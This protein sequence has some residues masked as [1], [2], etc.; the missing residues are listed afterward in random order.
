MDTGVLHGVM[1]GLAVLIS[2]VAGLALA[3]GTRWWLAD[4]TQ[5]HSLESSQA[6][7]RPM[8]IA[9]GVVIAA[10]AAPLFPTAAVLPNMTGWTAY[11]PASGTTFTPSDPN[12]FDPLLLAVVLGLCSAATPF[13]VVVDLLVRRLPDRIVLPLIALVALSCLLGAAFG[14]PHIWIVGLFAGIGATVFFGL[15]HLIGRLLRTST[16]GLG[17]VKLSFIVFTV[18]GLYS[19]WSPALVLVIMML[20]AGLVALAAIVSK[21]RLRGTSIAFGPSMLSGMWLGSVLSPFLL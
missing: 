6:Y 16:M 10:A 3:H 5:L 19:P 4:E 1:V 8:L 7:R 9:V 20:I 11:A 17:D 12:V 14:Q 13:L 18:A 15:L 2:I 21:G